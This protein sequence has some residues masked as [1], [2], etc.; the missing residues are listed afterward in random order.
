MGRKYSIE[1]MESVFE[2]IRANPGEKPGTIARLLGLQR[3]EVT[4]LLPAL[5]DQQYLLFE[6]ENGGLWPFKRRD[7]DR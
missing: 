1:R 5:E 4:R 7:R 3:S 2:K 6:D